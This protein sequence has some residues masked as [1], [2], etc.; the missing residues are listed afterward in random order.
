MKKNSFIFPAV[1]IAQGQ[2]IFNMWHENWKESVN[3]WKGLETN[4]DK[5]KYFYIGGGQLVN[6]DGGRDIDKTNSEL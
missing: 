6:S 4:I 5:T 3:N 1:F 2:G